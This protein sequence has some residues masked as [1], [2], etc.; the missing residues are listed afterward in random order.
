M[1]EDIIEYLKGNKAGDILIVEYDN[2]EIILKIQI[3]SFLTGEAYDEE[4]D[5]DVSFDA[6]L[7]RIIQ[8][9]GK[10]DERFEVGKLLE[11]S[12]FTYPDKITNENGDIIFEKK[13]RSR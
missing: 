12:K 3:C 9:M 11:I 6:C 8:I 2:G 7:S 10:S 4:L 5:E 1:N 13:N